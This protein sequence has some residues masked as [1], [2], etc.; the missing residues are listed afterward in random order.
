MTREETK[1]LLEILRIAYPRTYAN[2]SDTEMKEQIGFWYDMFKEYDIAIVAAACKGYVKSN[3]YPPTVAGLQRQID[4]LLPRESVAEA[5]DCIRKACK[6]GIYGAE[7]EFEKLPE[8]CKRWVVSVDAIREMARLTPE[9]MN[10][11]VKGE[12]IKTFTEVQKRAEA[13][14]VLPAEVRRVIEQ[15]KRLSLEDTYE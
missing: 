13:Q 11:V 8:D 10:T 1:Q 14:R 2:M 7:E 12:F 3:E 9:V 6:N 4:Y 15:S 5:F